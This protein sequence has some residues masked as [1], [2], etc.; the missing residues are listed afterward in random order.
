M[1]SFSNKLLRFILLV[2]SALTCCKPAYDVIISNGNIYDGSGLPAYKADLG[3]K[4]D[5]IVAIGDLGKEKAKTNIDAAGLAV[6]PGFINMLSW[7]NRPLLKDGRSMSDIKQGVT[8]E[9]FGEGSSMGPLNSNMKNEMKEA[10][11]TTLGGYLDYLVQQGVSTNVASFVGATTVRIHVLGYENRKPDAAELHQMQELVRQAMQ[12]GAMGLGTSLI[13]PP[14]FYADTEELIALAEAA[15]EYDGMYI[16]HLRSEGNA[17]LEAVDEFMTIAN[18]AGIDAEIY[19]LKA[20]GK[21]NWHKLDQVLQKID[22]ARAAG[23][24][25]AAN[26]YT[27]P[28]ASTGL[29]ATLPPWVQEGGKEAWLKRLRTPEVRQKV[30]DEMRSPSNTWENFYQMAGTAENIMLVGFDRDSLNHLV[31]KTLAEIAFNRNADPAE[32]I[33]DLILANGGDIDAIYFLMSEENVEKQIQLTYMSFGSDAGSIAAEGKSLESSTHPRTY[34][35]FAR[36]LAKYVREKNLISLEEAVMKMTALPARKLKIGNRGRL[37]PG[38]YADVL[39]FDP[40]EIQDKATF[41]NP[42]QYATGMLHVFVNGMQVL[43]N[44]THT[45]ATPGMVVRGPGYKIAP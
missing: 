35:N 29:D 14:A 22:S 38:Y 16:S 28:A 9:V 8:L 12:E 44:G 41:E 10:Q 1:S 15:A 33:I 19:H 39:V 11:W 43:K 23:L 6:S 40:A 5:K 2:F 32:T 7:A 13:Y 20:A 4:A 45:G 36:L 3:I 18:R 42:H 26:M 27:Y 24:T 34:G 37:A 17:F 31:G 30:L 21:N 25:V